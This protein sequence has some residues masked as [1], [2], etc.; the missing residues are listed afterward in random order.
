MTIRSILAVLVLTLAG[1]AP[2]AP[3]PVDPVA[4]AAHFLRLAQDARC[5]PDSP[6]CAYARM[7]MV[8]TIGGLLFSLPGCNPEACAGQAGEVA[9]AAKLEL[10]RLGQAEAALIPRVRDP[11]FQARADAALAEL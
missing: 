8:D 6:L 9:D 5:A 1:P 10:A 3:A 11:G 2:A 4:R 7:S